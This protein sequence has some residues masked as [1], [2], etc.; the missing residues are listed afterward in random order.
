MR[1]DPLPL[2][3]IIV[4]LTIILTPIIAVVVAPAPVGS[5][6]A[7]A[8]IVPAKIAGRVRVVVITA[9]IRVVA[10]VGVTIV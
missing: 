4:S 5:I 3:R 6:V 8:V 2:S 10:E 1:S 9:R 7:L